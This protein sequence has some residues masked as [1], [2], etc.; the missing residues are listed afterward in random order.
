M[1]NNPE[2]LLAT[3][4]PGPARSLKPG[5]CNFPLHMPVAAR[6]LL[7][8]VT[9][10]LHAKSVNRGSLRLLGSA[11]TRHVPRAGV[12]WQRIMVRNYG[13]AMVEDGTDHTVRESQNDFL[14]SI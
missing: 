5:T 4:K 6:Q 12:A 2:S 13:Q 10:V 7:G 14:E 1:I 9:T 11:I 3:K 8:R